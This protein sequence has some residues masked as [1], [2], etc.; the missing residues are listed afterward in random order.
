MLKTDTTKPGL[1]LKH[2]NIRGEEVELVEIDGK[3]F[4][5]DRELSAKEVIMMLS[6]YLINTKTELQ[7]VTRERDTARAEQAMPLR[8]SVYLDEVLLISMPVESI[9]HA[10]THATQ[11][12]GDTGWSRLDVT[13]VE[14]IESWRSA[15][16]TATSQEEVKHFEQKIFFDNAEPEVVATLRNMKRR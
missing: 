9:D 8:A 16:P 2:K 7:R 14:A 13:E 15:N 4:D 1:I 3:F 11:L 6:G 10:V 12:F 5:G